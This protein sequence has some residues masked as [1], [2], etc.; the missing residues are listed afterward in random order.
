[1]EHNSTAATPRE[2]RR[3]EI[4]SPFSVLLFSLKTGNAV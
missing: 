4:L 1:M 3:K 2:N